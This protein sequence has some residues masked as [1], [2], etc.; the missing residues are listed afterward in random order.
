[1]QNSRYNSKYKFIVSPYVNIDDKVGVVLYRLSEGDNEERKR[2]LW[3]DL[4][5]VWK[6]L[7]MV[8]IVN[9]EKAEWMGR[10]VEWMII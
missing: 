6:K 3:N 10:E 7:V 5:E 9:D 1:M 2:S 8:Q 4:D